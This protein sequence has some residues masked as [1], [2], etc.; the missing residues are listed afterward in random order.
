[1]KK[2]Y[3]YT[4]V[5][6]QYILT[7]NFHLVKSIETLTEGGLIKSFLLSMFKLVKEVPT[8][9]LI[10]VWDKSPY[11]RQQILEDYKGDRVY[12]T[13]EDLEREDLTEEEKKKIQQDIKEFELKTFV[14][15][16]LIKNSNKLGW[17]SLIIPGY[18]ADDLAFICARELK[19]DI[20]LAST[21]SDWKYFILE[22]SDHYNLRGVTTTFQEIVDKE[23]GDVD[24]FLH[25]SVIDSLYGSHNFLK[26]VST[27]AG[28]RKRKLKSEQII[29]MMTENDYSFAADK[30][31][32]IKQFSTFD[33]KSFP[34]YDEV[35]DR[36][37]NLKPVDQSNC[38]TES[39]FT[40]EAINFYTDL[41]YYYFYLYL[42][43]L[44]KNQYGD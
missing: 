39:E 11:H 26:N 41:D 7:R 3:D 5:D 15:Y 8:R 28:T 6:G 24:I 35:K 25:K 21:D 43:N 22:N 29:K 2:V 13:K 34:D 18:E 37:N 38:M 9:N 42:E 31:L 19:G 44:K 16:Y 12:S 17:N 30:D 33:V 32:F 23:S 4:V 10:V 27:T 14:K 20:C 40:Q 36:I 1:M